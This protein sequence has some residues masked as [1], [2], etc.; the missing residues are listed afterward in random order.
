MSW[1]NYGEWRIDHK[2]PLKYNKSSLEEVSQ[3]LHYTNKLPM[4]AS[5]NMSKGC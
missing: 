4:W 5:E 3:R 1:K 2:I